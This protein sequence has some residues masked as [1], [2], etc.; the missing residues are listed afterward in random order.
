MNIEEYDTIGKRL[1]YFREEEAKA[2]REKFAEGL[3]IT[4][5]TLER[6][7]S[8]LSAP[9]AAFLTKLNAKYQGTINLDWLLTGRGS[10]YVPGEPAPPAVAKEEAGQYHDITL[11]RMHEQLNRIYAEKDFLKLAAIQSLLNLADQKS[12][13]EE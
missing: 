10:L 11:E 12:K 7:E 4:A 8:D 5:R 1:R 3:G 2:T 13:K 6:Y 9:D